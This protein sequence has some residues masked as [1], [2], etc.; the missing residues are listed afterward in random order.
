MPLSLNW[1]VF[2]VCSPRNWFKEQHRQ[3]IR[4]AAQLTWHLWT[5][6]HA[7]TVL[8]SCSLYRVLSGLFLPVPRSLLLTV[9]ALAPA[10]FSCSP[11]VG[12]TCRI[13]GCPRSSDC[14]L[15]CSGESWGFHASEVIWAWQ[16]W[17]DY[18][19]ALDEAVT[20]M[21]DTQ[22]VLEHSRTEK[23]RLCCHSRSHLII[24]Y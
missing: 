13:L 11:A 24:V 3:S 12:N 16:R 18:P 10:I 23:N 21:E 1:T 5:L 19:E 22:V 2:C 15:Q 14:E 17:R 4:K 20:L 8:Q 6:I 7:M 9:P